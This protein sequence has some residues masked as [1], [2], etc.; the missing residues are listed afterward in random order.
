M[1]VPK[2][3]I[4]W[5]FFLYISI[6]YYISISVFQLPDIYYRNSRY[7]IGQDD[8]VTSFQSA[9]D[10]CIS[11]GAH[12]VHIN[13]EE[14]HDMIKEYIRSSGNHIYYSSM[15]DL[16]D[17][18]TET[19]LVNLSVKTCH[20]YPIYGVFWKLTWHPPFASNALKFAML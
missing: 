4:I 19:L 17:A 2:C 15:I 18:K 3:V 5:Y 14:E 12:S 7:L 13:S 8:S 16:F 20:L 11:L 1:H 9:M 6:C 10:K